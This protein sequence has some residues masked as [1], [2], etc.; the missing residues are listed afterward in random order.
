MIPGPGKVTVVPAP[1]SQIITPRTTTNTGI[2]QNLSTRPILAQPAPSRPSTIS[3]QPRAAVATPILR[4][5]TPVSAGTHALT[6]R[7]PIQQNIAG[8]IRLASPQVQ[9]VQTTPSTTTQPGTIAPR[10]STQTARPLN[11]TRPPTV[12]PVG[13]RVT[14]AAVSFRPTGPLVTQQTRPPITSPTAA[15]VSLIQT[16][17]KT[18]VSQNPAGIFKPITTQVSVPGQPVALR[19]NS[20]NTIPV[21][22][23]AG[24]RVSMVSGTPVAVS[25]TPTPTHIQV[26]IVPGAIGPPKARVAVP[27]QSIQKLV[28]GN[29]TNISMG[30]I[31]QVSVAPVQLSQSQTTGARTIQLPYSG[32]QSKTGA[33]PSTSI[34]V[35]R[36]I[37]QPSVSRDQQ[38]IAIS[39]GYV[40]AGAFLPASRPMDTS[41]QSGPVNL[42]VSDRSAFSRG[43]VAPAMTLPNFTQTTFLYEAGRADQSSVTITTL[44]APSE[45]SGQSTASQHHGPATI[46]PAR[47]TPIIPPGQGASSQ[48][49]QEKTV[50]GSPRPSILRKRPE[51]D[52]TPVK[53]TQLLTSPG[54]PPR[55]DSSGSSTISATSSLPA[56]SGDEQPPPTP[57]PTIEPSPRK[58]PRKQQLPPRETTT[59]ISP[60][61]AAV[62]RELGVRDR[63]EW[64]RSG[65]EPDWEGRVRNW[66]ND[67]WQ[68]SVKSESGWD[69][70][71]NQDQADD[72]DEMSSDEEKEKQPNFIQG[73]PHMS[74]LNSY[75]HTWKS[76][77]N[78]F[79]RYSDVK[80]KDE[81]RP[82]VNELANQKFVLQKINGWKIYHLSASMEDIV[83]MES[84]LSKRLQEI[85]RRL[86]ESANKD[87][88]KELVKVQELIK[89]NIQ[90][91]KV[92]Q[93]QVSEAKEN[94]QSI[95]EHKPKIQDIIVKYQSK[96]SLKGRREN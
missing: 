96:R 55:P 41:T 35:A 4:G 34:P 74:L 40:V 62:K 3:S 61:W 82:T 44:P 6:L 7:A 8:S 15:A 42:S 67:M 39:S 29:V 16:G 75:R 46:T 21:R 86:E 31:G 85:G 81:R 71:M 33:P 18:I 58:K 57:T 93:D 38:A 88:A 65:P 52:I 12:L 27:T 25:L 64:N 89:A 72:E 10:T 83:D 50:P 60:E 2:R 36:V 37:P 23:P 90:R 20:S 54:S 76:R 66:N 51:G 73:K 28:S 9:W 49:E 13:S 17:T 63:L 11:T 78:H 68:G 19:P 24:Q 87:V 59:N 69:Q 77:H 43:A 92:I 30:M 48:T 56:L 84:E 47:I 5:V 94:S 22:V 91:S 1:V 26:P 45:T 14:M 32:Q 79:L 95:F 53:G 70:D 80:S